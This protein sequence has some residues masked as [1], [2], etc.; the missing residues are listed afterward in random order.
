M[1]LLEAIRNFEFTVS[2]GFAVFTGL[3]V[4]YVLVSAATELIKLF[5]E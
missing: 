2:G 3:C 5:V 1:K 4:V